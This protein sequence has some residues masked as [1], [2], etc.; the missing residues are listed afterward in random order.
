MMFKSTSRSFLLPWK[1]LVLAISL[2]P[3]TGLAADEVATEDAGEYI[4]AS[5][6]N[7]DGSILG[8]VP[9]VGAGIGYMDHSKRYQTEGIPTDIRLLGSYYF[10]TKPLILDL[11]LGLRH[12]SYSQSVG[13]RETTSGNVEAAVRY[14]IQDQW[15]VGGAYQMMAGKGQHVGAKSDNAQFIGVQGLKEI[16]VKLDFPAV[17]RVGGRFMT[18]INITKE[19]VNYAMVEV[20]LGFP[21]VQTLARTDRP[22]RIAQKPVA[23]VVPQKIVLDSVLETEAKHSRFQI[24]SD[25]LTSEQRTYL[26]QVARGFAQQPHVVGRLHIVGH[27]DDTG[28]PQHNM[29]LSKRRAQA[30]AE[31][32][33]LNG[34]NA[35]MISVDWKG[36]TMPITSGNDE[37]SRAKNRRV[38][39]LFVNVRDQQALSEILS[40][41]VR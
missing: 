32:L 14:Q 15:S 1:Q 39:V 37:M 28:T 18:D 35:D 2:L 21:E 10:E 31:E 40:S 9:F 7:A 6:M 27:A 11:G 16:P 4:P 30:V 34:V 22:V 17:L 38:E 36:E 23:P 26:R 19:Q 33:R 29:Q 12:Q 13:G 41:T 5:T 3:M 8:F 24:D 20:A 25:V